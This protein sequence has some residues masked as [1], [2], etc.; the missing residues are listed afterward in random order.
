MSVARGASPRCGSGSPALVPLL[1]SERWSEQA[2]ELLREDAGMVVWW[3]GRVECISALRR[4]E[5]EG[6]L[7]AADADGPWPYWTRS[8]A[9][10]LRCSRAIP[11]CAGRA[12]ARGASLR[13]ADALQL[14]AALV[15]RREAAPLL[16]LVCLDERLRDAASREG[17]TALPVEPAEGGGGEAPRLA[18]LSW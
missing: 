15:W 7:D 16:R 10:G 14:G 2:G 3:G 12:G 18:G 8:P 9:L 4:R 17:F 1:F 6:A 13:A 11:S 5:R